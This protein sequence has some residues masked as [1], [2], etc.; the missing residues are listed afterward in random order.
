VSIS[1]NFGAIVFM[2]VQLTCKKCGLINDYRV[3]IKGVHHTAYCNG[4]DAYIKNVSYQ[5]P[6][7]F[8]GKYKGTLIADCKDVPYMKWCV[9][10]G[11]VKA[12]IKRAV[13]DRISEI[14]FQSK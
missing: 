2:D 10:E 7:F 4:C 9:K 13:E 11:V 6:Q 5:P 3:E 14:E 1:T 12:S 8:F